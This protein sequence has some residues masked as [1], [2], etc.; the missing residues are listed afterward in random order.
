MRVFRFLDKKFPV[1]EYLQDGG[2]F[3]AIK[4]LNKSL[5]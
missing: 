3:I 1:E 2:R 4:T 5:L